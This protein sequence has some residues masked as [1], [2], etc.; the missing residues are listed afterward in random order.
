MESATA[1]RPITVRP[2]KARQPILPRRVRGSGMAVLFS[3]GTLIES[4]EDLRDPEGVKPLPP[5]AAVLASLR[6]LGYRTGILKNQP[7]IGRGQLAWH[8]VEGV[9]RRIEELLGAFDVWRICPH[10]REDGCPCRIPKPGMVL[11]AAAKLGL[12]PRNIIVVG[13]SGRDM[14]AAAAAGSRGILIPGAST[15]RS[16]VMAAKEVA[17]D[18]HHALQLI[19]SGR[20]PQGK[21]A[22]DS[23][24]K[25]AGA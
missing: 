4:M 3:D 5:A 13:G 10:T 11:S 8:E 17:Q 23:K 21:T 25:A 12:A 14:V 15:L 2:I 6:S 18:L 20:R 16:D 19:V 7:E 24:S 1:E 22:P 9:N